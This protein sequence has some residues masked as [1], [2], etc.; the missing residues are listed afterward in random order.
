MAGVGLRG[1]AVNARICACHVPQGCPDS[2]WADDSSLI[3]GRAHASPFISGL[4]SGRDSVVCPGGAASLGECLLRPQ[5]VKVS[6][7]G[8]PEGTGSKVVQPR[9]QRQH[10]H[11]L[12][13]AVPGSA[14]VTP[15]PPLP[16]SWASPSHPPPHGC[17]SFSSGFLSLLTVCAE[18]APRALSQMLPLRP[19]CSMQLQHDVQ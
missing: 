10:A 14:P 5:V 16:S 9:T 18:L 13:R 17:T 15:V 4:K 3:C 6:R 8:G 1:R 19:Q 11:Q 2:A 7:A 12:C